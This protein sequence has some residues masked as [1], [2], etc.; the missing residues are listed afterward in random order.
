MVLRHRHSYQRQHIWMPKGFPC[1]NLLAEPL[2]RVLLVHLQVERAGDQQLTPIIFRKSLFEYVLKTFTATSRP[3]WSPFHTS[4][5]PPL[6][7]APPIRSYHTWIFMA[8]GTSAWRPQ[9]LYNDLRHFF[10]ICGKSSTSSNTCSTEGV[11][12]KIS[13]RGVTMTW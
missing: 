8:L 5:N 4:A 7:N 3:Q 12:V 9:T 2:Q 1:H 6:Y 13:Q 11:D 10:R